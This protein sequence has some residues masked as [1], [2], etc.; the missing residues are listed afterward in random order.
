MAGSRVDSILTQ[1]RV[2][3]VIVVVVLVVV[4]V[5]GLTIQDRRRDAIDIPIKD[6]FLFPLT[7]VRW[8]I[9]LG[10]WGGYDLLM[11]ERK[12]FRLVPPPASS[13]LGKLALVNAFL[14]MH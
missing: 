6:C 11:L 7:T 8:G 12:G 10:A 1:V 13:V 3:G 4:A 9:T 2:E 14:L 5:M